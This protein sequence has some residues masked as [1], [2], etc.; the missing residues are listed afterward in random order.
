MHGKHLRIVA[1]LM[2]RCGEL[3]V[4]EFIFSGTSN[5]RYR[6]CIITR[7]LR[8]RPTKR[9]NIS[10]RSNEQGFMIVQRRREFAETIQCHATDIADQ[11]LRSE[12]CFDVSQAFDWY[13]QR[14]EH[15]ISKLPMSASVNNPRAPAIRSS[16]EPT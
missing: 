10:F 2:F 7:N 14:Y 8:K 6:F 3:A 15:R 4:R 9:M 12:R 13:K 11:N 1:I 16:A 5:N